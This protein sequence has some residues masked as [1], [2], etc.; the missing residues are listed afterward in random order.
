MK[1][2]HLLI[3]FLVLLEGTG[4]C[5]PLSESCQIA[6]FFPR[7]QVFSRNSRMKLKNK[8]LLEIKKAEKRKQERLYW[9]QRIEALAELINDDSK[10]GR[11]QMLF[12]RWKLGREL[13]LCP[14]THWEPDFISKISG[15]IKIP[16]DLLRKYMA[17]SDSFERISP[18]LDWKTYETLLK[19]KDK[20]ERLYC[21]HAAQIH[22]WST[23]DLLEFI[24]KEKYR[25]LNFQ[26]R[27]EVMKSFMV[28]I[29]PEQMAEEFIKSSIKQ[30][31][32]AVMKRNRRPHGCFRVLY[33]EADSDPPLK[34][35]V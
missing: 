9:L 26:E 3:F 23:R 20:E 12:I 31:N 17:F 19:I 29:D 35:W 14:F 34:Y 6:G 2:T 4:F 25:R 16:E 5:E 10:S 18:S 13:S 24:Q 11:D 8:R 7:S 28:L 27:K 33:I 21:H 15:I 22:S 1:T 32:I 30:T